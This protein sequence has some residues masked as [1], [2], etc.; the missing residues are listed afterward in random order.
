[1]EW[2]FQNRVILS[3]FD[4]KS[5]KANQVIIFS[6]PTSI[7][8]MK[9]LALI[10]CEIS[11]TQDFQILFWKGHNSK[12]GHNLDMKKNMDQLFF[13]EKSVYEISKP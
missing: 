7:P 11:R 4:G 5:S 13:H 10:L 3:K 1:M 12:Q 2:K 9:A 6:A 8:N